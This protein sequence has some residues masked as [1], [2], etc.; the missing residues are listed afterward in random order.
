MPENFQ[1]SWH[2]AAQVLLDISRTSQTL[3][4]PGEP[5][6]DHRE[7]SRS[8]GGSEQ[9]PP[10]PSKPPNYHSKRDPKGR[11]ALKEEKPKFVC[12]ICN[13]ELPNEWKLKRHQTTKKHIEK[14][15]D[16]EEVQQTLDQLEDEVS[17]IYAGGQEGRYDLSRA[18]I[19]QC[20]EEREILYASPC[21]IIMEDLVI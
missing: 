7:T 18:T 3:R 16:K 17:N 14:A 4:R 10:Q 9:K 12:D 6:V 20:I 1:T 8:F 19:S 21:D 11:W 15:K 2:Q 13:V 5:S